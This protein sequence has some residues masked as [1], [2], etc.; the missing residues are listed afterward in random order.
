GG[1]AL[2]VDADHALSVSDDGASRAS[3]S[4]SAVY[5]RWLADGAFRGW[6][7][8]TRSRASAWDREWM[9][10]ARPATLEVR[11]RWAPRHRVIVRSGSAFARD[12][13]GDAIGMREPRSL[14]CDRCWLGGLR[15]PEVAEAP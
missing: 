12:A 8:L 5:V 7:V 11:L 10:V 4:G 2:I 1:L 3:W 15:P 13:L 9:R 14:E 6:N